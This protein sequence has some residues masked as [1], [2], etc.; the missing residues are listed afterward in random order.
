MR[1]VLSVGAL[2]TVLSCADQPFGPAPEVPAELPPFLISVEMEAAYLD[3]GL[4]A[5]Q[6]L[7]DHTVS[8]LADGQYTEI[9]VRSDAG[10]DEVLRVRPSVCDGSYCRRLR[11]TL[12]DGVPVSPNAEAVHA[13]GAVM[14]GANETLGTAFV[15]A[16][17]D[18]ATVIRRLR[19]LAGVTAVERQVPLSFAPI[20]PPPPPRAYLE[21]QAFFT[22][23]APLTNDGIVSG[24]SGDTITIEY[25]QPGTAP[26]QTWAFVLP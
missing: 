1:T 12:A 8:S 26:P 2:L 6:A 17:D 23:G 9:R 3:R 7:M 16:V 13:S 18:P 24:T 21:A 25:L 19:R 15:R 20:P 11:V 14:V 5:I 10:E 22:V 4:F